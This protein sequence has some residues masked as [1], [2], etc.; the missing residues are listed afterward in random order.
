[1]ESEENNV[2]NREHHND[3]KNHSWFSWSR[4]HANVLIISLSCELGKAFVLSV[5]LPDTFMYTHGN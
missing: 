3:I 2:D 5:S 4:W 1:M